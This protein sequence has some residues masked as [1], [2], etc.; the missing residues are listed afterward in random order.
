[1]DV[2]WEMSRSQIAGLCTGMVAKATLLESSSSR[3][4]TGSSASRLLCMGSVPIRTQTKAI[5]I[6]PRV[7]GDDHE[8]GSSGNKGAASP[9]ACTWPGERGEKPG[10]EEELREEVTELKRLLC[11]SE[12]RRR[13]AEAEFAA[14]QN[15]V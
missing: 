7:H 3:T 1:M 4:G 9:E 6:P 15:K 13:E 2:A 12:G 14:A 10:G 5:R 8:N 11:E